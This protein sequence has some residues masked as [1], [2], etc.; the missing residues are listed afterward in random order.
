MRSTNDIFIRWLQWYL[1]NSAVRSHWH[2]LQFLSGAFADKRNRLGGIN[3][4]V[5]MI[6]IFVPSK[7]MFR[8]NCH[9]DSIKK[10]DLQEVIRQL[11]L[12]SW[13]DQ[14]H[15]CG[16]W[17][18]TTGQHPLEKTSTATFFPLLYYLYIVVI[19]CFLPC[20][21]ATDPHQTPGIS[22]WTSQ[23]IKLEAYTFL[24]STN[25]PICCILLQ[26]YKMTK[27]MVE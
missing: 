16:Y 5:A 14:C 1:E 6:C 7:L 25:S 10:W 21:D 24:I 20:F 4:K 18:F 3:K 17:L 19:W 12:P 9:W 23:P 22:L 27:V 13:M 11:F 15:C 8:L 26:Q 2:N